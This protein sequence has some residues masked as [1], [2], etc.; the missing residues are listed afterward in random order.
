MSTTFRHYRAAI[1]SCGLFLLV[2]ALAA[3]SA[4]LSHASPTQ[5]KVLEIVF[6]P[7]IEAQGGVR[8]T[9]LEGWTQPATVDPQY[10]TDI[11]TASHDYVQYSIQRVVVDAIPQKKDGFTY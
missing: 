1:L 6:D 7:V 5:F 8:L 9:Q 11:Q 4:P 10:A 3:R 2:C